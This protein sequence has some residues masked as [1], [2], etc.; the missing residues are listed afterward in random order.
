MLLLK[1]AR[2]RSFTWF[3]VATGIHQHASAMLLR[4]ITVK[5][6]SG[7]CG[8]AWLC[9][10]LSYFHMM[11]T[12]WRRLSDWN[13]VMTQFNTTGVLGFHLERLVLKESCSQKLNLTV[14]FFRS[15][16]A[17]CEIW[18]GGDISWHNT[19]HKQH[20]QGT[21]FYILT[22]TK[23]QWRIYKIRCNG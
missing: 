13:P 23:C 3:S 21:V 17:Q 9:T 16:Y 7:G 2:G 14:F 1:N 4:G 10:V 20:R 8:I 15:C 11:C 12:W 19:A 22:C 5:P 18:Y 6:T